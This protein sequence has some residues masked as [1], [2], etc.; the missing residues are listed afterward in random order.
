M[1]RLKDAVRSHRLFSHFRTSNDPDIENDADPN[2]PRNENRLP[3]DDPSTLIAID[4]VI[5][6]EPENQNAKSSDTYSDFLPNLLQLD[7]PVRNHLLPYIDA[8]T[9]ASLELVNRACL[10]AIRARSYW[11]NVLEDVLKKPESVERRI[12]EFYVQNDCEVYNL[13]Y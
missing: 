4:D 12:G 11:R 1:T 6:V 3:K 7:V 2:S 10:R 5:F 13:M 8:C 9:L